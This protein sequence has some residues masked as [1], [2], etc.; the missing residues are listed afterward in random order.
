MEPIDHTHI[1]QPNNT[2]TNNTGTDKQD[3]VSVTYK[4]FTHK[5]RANYTRADHSRS[6]NIF[7]IVLW[8][9]DSVPNERIT[10]FRSTYKCCTYSQSHSVS[11]GGSHVTGTHKCCTDAKP[12]NVWSYIYVSDSESI[13][14]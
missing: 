10:H 11:Y 7:S 9:Y 4:S 14:I 13:F 5:R 2:G 6:H 3:T 1:L 12:D 8:T